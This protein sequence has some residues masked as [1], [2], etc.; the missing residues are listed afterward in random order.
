M[1]RV[2]CV[3]VLLLGVLLWPGPA[4]SAEQGST[5]A[6]AD[7]TSVTQSSPT[8]DDTLAGTT[9]E[10]DA[11]GGGGSPAPWLIGSGLAAIAAVGI[12]GSL[13]KRRMG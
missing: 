13:L 11:R 3:A 9:L 10:A 6:G 2:L 8:T 12:G 5:S 1:R 7:A 4:V